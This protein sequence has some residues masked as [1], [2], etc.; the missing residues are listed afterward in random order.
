MIVKN[1]VVPSIH[2]CLKLRKRDHMGSFCSIGKT[3]VYV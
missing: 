1:N 3:D 2:L